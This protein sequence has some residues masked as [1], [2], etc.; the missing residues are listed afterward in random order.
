VLLSLFFQLGFSQQTKSA[1]FLG[2]S[3][4]YFNSMS[5][6]IDN[7]ALDAGNGLVH[8]SNTPGG[9]Q[10]HQ[11]ASNSTSLAKIKQR[12][13][14]Y[15]I[16]QAQSQEPSFSPGQV[17]NNTYPFA[18]ILN[19][20]ILA[21]NPC[22]EPLFFMTWGRKNGDASNCGNYPP[23]CTYD[24]M[25]Q[26]LKES[27]MEMASDNEASVAP[28]GVA[29]KAVR[30]LYPS[31][32]LYNPDESHPSL[33]GSYL[34]ACVFYVSMFRESVIGNS[35][36]S[37]LDST[38][39]YRLQVIASST[40]LDSLSVWGIG[41][42]DQ[43]ISLPADTAFCGDSF[44]I[45]I[46]GLYLNLEWSNGETQSTSITTDTSGLVYAIAS[47]IRNCQV[48]DSMNVSLSTN[49]SS[50]ENFSGCDSLNFA[51]NTYYEDT[52]WNVIFAD[53]SF[54][55]SVHMIS[56]DIIKSLN[57][58]YG[59]DSFATSENVVVIYANDWDSLYI[60]NEHSWSANDISNV[61]RLV[62]NSYFQGYA[63]A[64]N[65]CGKDSVYISIAFVSIQELDYFWSI[66]PN[67]VNQ[68]LLISSDDING[69]GIKMFDVLGREVAKEEYQK[70]TSR[71]IQLDFLEPGV[72]I[73]LVYDEDSN[74]IG[75]RTIQKQ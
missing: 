20:S 52:T 70:T 19:D 41:A 60:R 25:Q 49:A 7:L 11:H 15:I 1:L 16:I 58:S 46:S 44:T 23:I 24:G 48:S 50:I 62:F 6:L 45:G 34:A 68:S 38:A 5:T 28:V 74:P 73:L 69:F 71:E 67:P 22:T 12:D 30:D 4:T 61:D 43:S 31:I 39:A 75:Q 53:S 21:N 9:Y 54:C 17:A 27:Y 18:A 57:L 47:N 42:N 55:D 51:G 64:W 14:D 40:V 3:Y 35:F 63:L 8:D 66:G 72:Y 29:W 36:I 32:E 65:A 37:T 26:R 59:E 33:E 13:W 10:L 2:N 56:L